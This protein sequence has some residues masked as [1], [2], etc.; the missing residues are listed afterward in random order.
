MA[1]YSEP[2]PN[3][4]NLSIRTK[5]DELA[6]GLLE[7]LAAN[8][9]D[10]WNWLKNELLKLEGVHNGLDTDWDSPII[11]AFNLHCQSLQ[12][13][14]DIEDVVAFLNAVKRERPE[15]KLKLDEFLPKPHSYVKNLAIEI[16]PHYAFSN[17]PISDK[18]L[19]N[20]FFMGR[21]RD[22]D[23]F[24]KL[25]DSRIKKGVFLVTGYRG[26]GK[27]SFVNKA[28]GE[29]RRR[30]KDLE[31]KTISLN[32]A[33]KDPSE[34]DILKLMVS[35]LYNFYF[36]EKW[37]KP[38]WG[39]SWLKKAVIYL[40]GMVVVL[41]G[42]TF[43]DNLI[44]IITL[45]SSNANKATVSQIHFII[46]HGGWIK[47][48]S[49]GAILF[50]ILCILAMIVYSLFRSIS[51]RF[52]DHN[53]PRVIIQAI[54]KRC[55][56][57]NSIEKGR[58]RELKLERLG[59]GLG[60]TEKE[61]M[62]YPIA[63]S[64]E[65]E[66]ELD[67]FLKAVVKEGKY[68]FIFIFDELDKIEPA[69]VTTDYIDEEHRTKEHRASTYLQQ[70]RE[71]KQ[72][73]INIIAGLK[74]FLT[75][76]EARFVF[77]AGRE[78]FDATLADVADRQS[79]I[80]SIFNY[81]FYIESFLKETMGQDSIKSSLSACIEHY[82]IFVL[83]GQQEDHSKGL[84]LFD[85]LYQLY[86]S[87]DEKIVEEQG[88]LD[89]LAY[90]EALK[91][92]TK[93]RL[94]RQRVKL[95][96]GYRKSLI[97]LQNF[98]VYL[99][100]RS[101]GSPKKIIKLIQEFIRMEDP[102]LVEKPSNF[103][104][105][106]QPGI[107]K[108]PY[109]YFGFDDQYRIGFINHLY[110]P[111]LIRY[112]QSFNKYSDNIILSTTYLFDHLL[113]FHP[114]AFS[115]P[116][117]ELTPEVLSTNKTPLLREHI[118]TIIDYLSNN[119]LRE[120]EIGIFDYKFYSRTQSELIYIS[121]TFEAE[122]AAFN[123]TLDEGYLIK[124]HIRAELRNLREV[125]SKYTHGKASL[126]L[127]HL[128]GILGDLHFFDQEY[129]EA[130]SAYA[131]CIRLIGEADNTFENFI[132]SQRFRLKLGLTLEKV[133]SYDDALAHY[134]DATKE[135]IK[136]FNRYPNAN[137]GEDASPVFNDILQIV[138]QGFLALIV[139]QEK[140]GIDGITIRNILCSMNDFC[141]LVDKVMKDGSDDHLIRANMYLVAGNLLYF[142]NPSERK[143]ASE[144]GIK[145]IVTSVENLAL[146]LEKLDEHLKPAILFYMHGLSGVLGMQGI[147]PDL[148][149]NVVYNLLNKTDILHSKWKD[150]TLG[151]NESK[152][153]AMFLSHIGDCLLSMIKNEGEEGTLKYNSIKYSELF[154]GSGNVEDLLQVI[155]PSKE[156]EIG[157]VD[158][159]RCYYWSAR[160]FNKRG[161]HVSES[162]QLRKVL[163]VLQMVLK[164][165]HK[166]LSGKK[167]WALN[168][169]ETAVLRPILTIASATAEHSDHHMINKFKQTR[170]YKEGNESRQKSF[171]VFLNNNI[172]NHPDTREAISL[173]LYI[174]VK[175][176]PTPKLYKYIPYRTFI[177][178]DH[179]FATQYTRIYELHFWGKLNAMRYTKI[180]ELWKA[181]PIKEMRTRHMAQEGLYMY[182]FDYLHAQ[183]SALLM[184]DIYGPDY[185]ISHSLKG[186]IHYSIGEF[187]REW[188]VDRD[189]DIPI[190]DFVEFIARHIGFNPQGSMGDDSYHYSMAIGH[191]TKAKQLHSQGQEYMKN[192]DNLIYLEDDINDNAYHFGAAYDRY[193]MINDTFDVIIKKS[194]KQI[195]AKKA[196]AVSKVSYKY[197]N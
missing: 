90:S 158:V 84:S 143:V 183:F 63:S 160:F 167:L 172:S 74:N 190:E 36:S 149:G 55:Y 121:K 87:Q 49:I 16:D 191:M 134:G 130:I 166:S 59:L 103:V 79:S 170:Y 34:T 193:L 25:L 51:N 128:N 5:Q 116:N 195:Q 46:S 186:F 76:A 23:K 111:F 107:I 28:I 164:V 188:R 38:K 175:L 151:K 82:L 137:Y 159:I 154:L 81:V 108:A 115:I 27:T 32:L 31:V 12:G 142:K 152:Y 20:E 52:A 109:L 161:R 135:A 132:R 62:N 10:A 157:I 1:L 88:K 77:I 173:F 124:L 147:F 8:A 35:H 98:I 3:D 127:S 14:F 67:L 41:S 29:Y 21:K 73:V 104:F 95:E 171:D 140:M 17:S 9:S 57:S 69:A 114:F 83:F 139:L 168:S 196:Q 70:I 22:L 105:H 40:V 112:G 138:N 192:M 102:Q 2:H 11:K 26:M 71:R 96:H 58:Q 94:K 4:I 174:Q 153:L 145:P 68:E 56:S 163:Y 194:E 126:S 120:T 53:S 44:E 65:I 6:A 113:K 148:K 141:N 92:R 144:L 80:S 18:L 180:K 89:S 125:H 129:D 150:N 106:H 179:S 100:Y 136:F 64:K 19:N 45:R 54:Y 86:L 185:T 91:I 99:T 66:Y 156:F 78:M 123:F 184:M 47:Y 50:T 181:Y 169:I 146:D 162:F 122:S 85:I 133:K 48:V 176:S 60:A 75:T 37:E 189:D 97:V 15:L 197:Y 7:K 101:N 33:Q 155:R 30:L 182:A 165:D 93:E 118:L 119:H 24:G 43:F 72:S 131:D 110:R 13:D 39:D 177:A 61:T 178:P 117:L 187:I 42:I